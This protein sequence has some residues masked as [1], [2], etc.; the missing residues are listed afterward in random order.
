M[1]DE[2]ATQGVFT[3]ISIGGRF[4]WTPTDLATFSNYFK[5][6][7]A[8]NIGKDGRYDNA[9]VYGL[10][11]SSSPFSEK[12]PYLAFFSTNLIPQ[13]KE[14]CARM[15]S[16]GLPVRCFK[17]DIRNEV[18]DRITDIPKSECEALV[19]FYDSTNGD[20]WTKGYSGRAGEVGKV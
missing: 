10:Y 8:G 19:D 11:R 3:G 7:M 9:V 13:C 14:T 4:S 20:G 5:L 2:A 1:V 12:S 6:P 18:C 16:D 17:N 15:R